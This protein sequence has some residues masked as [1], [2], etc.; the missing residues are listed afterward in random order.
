MHTKRFVSAYWVELTHLFTQALVETGVDTLIKFIFQIGFRYRVYIPLASK[1]LSKHRI[2][3]QT[4]EQLI[5]KLTET[6][7]AE[8]FQ[9]DSIYVDRKTNVRKSRDPSQQLGIGSE[10]KR[11]TVTL[12]E[13]QRA[14]VQCSRRISKEDWLE[15]LRRFNI[16]LIKESPA[17]SIRS[18]FPI[19][20]ACVSVA[21]DLFNPA[22]LSCW[23]ELSPDDQKVSILT[24]H[25]LTPTDH[26]CAGFDWLT[27]RCT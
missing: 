26:T 7:D 23:N 1:I 22:F 18:C 24:A 3:H 20:Q 2:Q 9:Y 27:S 10:V 21:R 16:D 13:I 15:W 17:L 5:V 14:W 4:Y 12:E 25:P 19:A 11:N 6:T 8:D